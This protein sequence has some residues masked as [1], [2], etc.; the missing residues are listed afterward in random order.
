MRPL[1][2]GDLTGKV[3]I[4]DRTTANQHGKTHANQD[5]GDTRAAAQR[6]FTTL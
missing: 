3:I 1:D 2:H 5:R 4:G 6:S